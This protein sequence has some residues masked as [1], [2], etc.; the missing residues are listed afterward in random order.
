[1]SIFDLDHEFPDIGPSEARP[2]LRRAARELSQRG[3]VSASTWALELLNCVPTPPTRHQPKPSSRRPFL[4]RN[5]STPANKKPRRSLFPNDGPSRINF[6]EHSTPALGFHH[7]G[8]ER[9]SAGTGEEE[10][11]LGSL[12]E[13]QADN[14]GRFAMINN[15]TVSAR[16]PPSPL[17]NMMM[18]DSVVRDPQDLELGRRRG[19]RMAMDPTEEVSCASMDRQEEEMSDQ[20]GGSA[21]VHWQASG[22]NSIV[23]P[24]RP[25]PPLDRGCLDL[26]DDSVGDLYDDD[27][28]EGEDEYEDEDEED[29]M[30]EDAFNLAKSLFDQHQLERCAWTLEHAACKSDKSRFLRLYAKFLL[31]ERRLDEHGAIIPKSTGKLPSTS[32]GLIPLLQEL[33]DPEDCFLL[34][35]KGVIFR[36]LQKRVEAMECFI[37]SVQSFPYNWSAWQE[38][39]MT[40]DGESAELE[41]IADLL[42]DTFMASFFH[43]Y[44]VRQSTRADPENLKRIDALL[45]HFPRSAHLLTCR[46]ETLYF[47][48]EH[49]EADG[50]FQEALSVDPYRLDG[51]SEYSNTLYL[52]NKPDQLAQLAH[53]FAETGKNRPEVSCLIG[54]YYNQKGD[55]H[56]AIESFKHAL[57]LDLGCVP[58]W[59]LL[60][61]EYLELKNSHAA[62]EMYRR[63]IEI[64]P[65]DYRAW[66]GL[67]QVY[68][69]NESWSYAIHYYQKCS[70]IRPYD[71]RMWVSM[72]VCYD[73]LGRSNDAIACYKRHLTCQLNQADTVAGMVRIIEIYEKEGNLAA[74]APYHR[75]LVQVVDRSLAG[76]EPLSVARF[77]RSYI[78]AARW[79]MGEVGGGAEDLLKNGVAERG[80]RGKDQAEAAVVGGG[81]G[82]GLGN[83]ALANDYLQKVVLAGTEMT[84]LAEALLKRLA[85]LRD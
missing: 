40:L 84:D 12:G 47:N 28:L 65:Q 4:H 68:E 18:M 82:G 17:S 63:A 9:K 38:L 58:A 8:V 31:S 19:R 37:R 35:L 64:N 79:E 34:F 71:A 24:P 54:N 83:L 20:V 48:Q 57:R 46:A 51:I 80:K 13:Q 69:L 50:A 45:K 10:G 78:I 85:F 21:H 42:P 56:R 41:Q 7:S 74:A 26:V 3:L 77:A 59:I 53:K 44:S 75:R 43:E 1:M 66:H 2:A 39:C 32:P 67:G 6:P 5:S 52:L 33:I 27:G 70:T 36:K 16:Y 76:P 22:D 14:S 61:H 55:H 23:S 62:A 30:E 25:P 73:K 15:S 60:G 49:E 81:G 29:Q 72:G 11:A